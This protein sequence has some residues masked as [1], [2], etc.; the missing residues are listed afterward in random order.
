[1]NAQRCSR[2]AL[3]LL[4]SVA[5]CL[6]G[7]SKSARLERHLKRGDAAYRKGDL[8]TARIEYLNAFRVDSQ[9]AH[10]ITQL[11]LIMFER[12]EFSSAGPFLARAR[13]LTPTNINVRLKLGSL[14]AVA[15]Q[16]SNAV[17]EV[18]FV[19]SRSPGHPEA[20]QM[21]ANF[22][23]SQEQ[24]VQLHQRFQALAQMQPANAAVPQA[25]A[26]LYE[27]TGKAR[28]AEAAYQQSLKLSP[29]NSTAA[30]GLGNLYWQLGRTN[31]AEASLKLAS[32][33]A[34][35]KSLERLRYAEFRARQGDA[36][37]AKKLLEDAIEKVPDFIVAMNTLAEMALQERDTNQCSIMLERALK[38]DPNH[39]ASLL[40]RSRLRLLQANHAGAIADLETIKRAYANDPQVPYQT[41]LVRLAQNDT[42]QAL[43]EL[44]RALTLNTNFVEAVLVR[45]ELLL[46]RNEAAA[47]IPTLT[48]VVAQYPRLIQA[49]YLLA[50]AH[51]S[52]GT[53]DD[54]IA[55]YQAIAK[56]TP[57]EP[58]PHQEMGVTYRL[59]R[60]FD[61]AY[62]A[63]EAALA[64]NPALLQPLD[65]L[66]EI[67]IAA[68]RFDAA[69]SRV[70]VYVD[71]H[72]E[73]P[74]PLTLQAKVFFAHNKPAEAEAALQKAIQLAPDFYL[75][76][77]SLADFYSRTK[78]LESAIAKYREIVQKVPK[79]LAS[80]LQLGMLLEITKDYRGARETYEKLLALKPDNIPALN[81][82]AYVLSEHLG[83]VERAAPLAQKA[84]DLRPLDTHTADTYGWILFK[85]GDY[86][87]ALNLIRQASEGMSEMPEVRY[88]LGMVNYMM[89]AEPAARAALQSAVSS[90][91]DFT[92]KE[93]ATRVLA[94]LSADT[95]AN[96]PASTVELIRKAIEADPKDLFAHIRLAQSM[97]SRQQFDQARDLY[98]KALRINPRA[99]SVLA[100]L[101]ALYSERFGNSARAM[102][103]ARQSWEQ[104]P[105]AAAAPM[106]GRVGYRAGEYRWASPILQ[107]AV[108]ADSSGPPAYYLGLCLYS[109]GNT[110]R[111]A[112]QLRAAAAGKPDAPETALAQR[113][114][115]LLE[116]EASGANPEPAR[117][118]AAEFLKSEPEFPPA[119]LASARL[120]E[121]KANVPGARALLENL[122]R[123]RPQN[124]QAQRG[125]VLLLAAHQLDDN[126]AWQ[127]ATTLRSEFSNDA[128]LNKALGR[129]AYR[130]SD[131]REAARFLAQT[132]SARPTDS[133]TLFYLGLAQ[134]RLKD[135]QAKDSLT[136]ALAMNANSPL[137]AEALKAIEEIK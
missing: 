102:E 55:I 43:A 76:Q 16:L 41:A 78:Q 97:E 115:A 130:K 57:K 35:P 26:R 71:K 134:H 5:F 87:R 96:A 37:G 4:L 50:A 12:S 90:T 89:G 24:I 93:Q 31:E 68:R 30:L 118:I 94:V 52:R 123:A 66:I 33:H 32:D 25:L 85:Q 69:L 77:K 122:V 22:A 113:A 101:A 9:S 137:R 109:L 51:R 117:Q 15:G 129:I 21:L 20:L 133:E 53:Y 56:L 84:H 11:G 107:Q 65:D 91:N 19:L 104:A 48:R 29:T 67:D 92:G 3:S 126:K 88:H 125:L 60:K 18:E 49:Q 95:S 100:P 116:F 58:R 73:H 13:E 36:A 39:R 44:D 81:N 83:E 131:F 120:E 135:K 119:V 61:D 70:Q 99:G 82:L 72:P 17:S 64:I 6:S 34:A 59:Q 79:D 14:M 42:T 114:L 8:Q 124:L 110:A 127:M 75:A 106:L 23:N 62:K 2:I 10:A 121:A 86:V 74:L 128:D 136:R 45:S 63:F 47:A 108:S 38:V 7:C 46:R 132:V 28:E 112:E 54:A 1:M 27:R 98:E 111:A 105:S 103:L 40:N 80:L